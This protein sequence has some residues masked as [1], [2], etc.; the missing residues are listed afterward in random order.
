VENVRIENGELRF[1]N[2]AANHRFVSTA[3]YKYRWFRWN[4]A[5]YGKEPI[6]NAA[7]VKLPSEI[8]SADGSYMGCTL[9][10]T[11]RPNLSVTAYFRSHGGEWQLVGIDR[12]SAPP[13]LP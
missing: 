8:A 10:D 5:R 6:T 11:A 3:S 1:D 13:S 12:K 4:N 2:L 9:A 7:S